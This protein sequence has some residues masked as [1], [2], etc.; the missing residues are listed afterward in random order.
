MSYRAF[1][2]EPFPGLPVPEDVRVS[3]S[4]R[5]DG[6]MLEL[7]WRLE[8]PDASFSLPGPAEKPMRSSELWEHTCFEGFLAVPG[9]PGYREFNLSPAGH[10]NVF[11]FASYRSG[12]VEE[13][14]FTAL[15]CSVSSQ[16]GVCQV[17]ARIDTTRLGCRADPWLLAI[18]T[19]VATPEGRLSYW[20]LSHPGPRPDFHHPGAFGLQLATTE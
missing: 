14:A 17:S 15:P 4:A 12:M 6:A 5:R 11:R 9:R 2:L 10:W 16:V 19:V 1:V 18:A 8:G 20:A 13:E 7:A 3:G